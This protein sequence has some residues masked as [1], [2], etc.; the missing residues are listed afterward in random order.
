M[1]RN[2]LRWSTLLGLVLVVSAGNAGAQSLWDAAQ[3]RGR[4]L[5]KRF[6]IGVFYLTQDQDYSIDSLALGIDSIDP[7]VAANL[8]IENS[9]DTYYVAADYWVLPFLNVYALLGDLDGKTRVHLSQI[10][11]GLPLGDIDIEYSG[12][13][14]GAGVVL[15]G[16]G[17]HVFVLADLSYSWTD[18]D[19]STSSVE[20]FIAT[21][22]V[23]YDFG[24]VAVW[25]GAMYQD[26]DEHHQGIVEIPGLGPV[27]YD[28]QLS[29][30]DKWNYT[31]GLNAGLGE[32]WVLSLE[33]GFGPRTMMLAQVNYR[34]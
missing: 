6:G 1:G 4:K 28:I 30:K 16:G 3:A 33:G 18:L 29:G 17:E 10:N 2:L 14:Y 24:Q 31:A 15:V 8:P 11:I 25:V 21:P 32:H 12:L 9:T 7:S 20:A 34:F 26:P 27:P 19:V 22:R 5:P 23:G 13:L